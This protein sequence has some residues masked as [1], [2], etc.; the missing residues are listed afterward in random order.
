MWAGGGEW[1]QVSFD[2]GLEEN[3]S[4]EGWR[5]CK[6]VAIVPEDF[7]DMQL[8]VGTIAEDKFDFR[9]K[10]TEAR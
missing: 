5:M 8:G 2:Q 4:S 6:R 9:A 10:D 3:E 7:V 1:A